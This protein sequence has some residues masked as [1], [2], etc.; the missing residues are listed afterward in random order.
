[1]TNRPLALIYK[2]QEATL[3][4]ANCVGGGR[5]LVGQNLWS[6]LLRWFVWVLLAVLAS[7]SQ[8]HAASYTLPLVIGSAPFDC[9]L[10]SGTTY[11]CPASITLGNDDSVAASSASLT[12]NVAGDVTIPNNV[13]W[14]NSSFDINVVAT[15]TVTLGNSSNTDFFGN[16]TAATVDMGN[17]ASVSGTCTTNGSFSNSGNCAGGAF[18]NGCTSSTSGTVTTV[19]CTSNGSFT[20]PS[21]IT[22][23][24]VEAWGG[25]G[26]G[27]AATGNPDK[28]GGGAGGQYAYK[29][30]SVSSSTTYTVVVGAGGAGGNSSTGGTGGDST[31]NTNTV[32]AK[33]GAGGG[34]AGTNGGDGAAASGSATGGIG[35]FV[36]RGGNSTAGNSTTQCNNGGAGGGGAGIIGNGGNASGNT[37]GTGTAAGG[38]N[39]GAGIN[40]SGDGNAGNTLGGGGGGACAE[41]NANT[42]GG[43]GAAGRV[44]IT[45]S[46]SAPSPIADWRMD[47]TTAYAGVA[48]E[49]KNSVSAGTNATAKRIAKTPPHPFPGNISGKLCG[50][51]EF[52]GFN[53]LEVVGLSSQL[54]GTA[55]L[56]FWVKTT[57][58]GNNTPWAAPG[59][60]GV[61][62]G[63]SNDI[64]WGYINATGKMALH[65]GSTAGAQSTT[66]I[67]D[68]TWR[69]IVLTRNTSSP[70]ESNIYVNGV[71]EATRSMAADLSL[72]TT[73]FS[74]LGR[75]ETPYSSGLSGALD[76]LKIFGPVLSATQVA[77]I[78]ANESAGKN[79]DGSARV[80]P[81]SGPDHYELSLPSISISCLPTTV[82]VT[83]CADN[84]SPCTNPVTTIAGKTAV[85]ATSAGTLAATTVTFNAAG[86]AST[87][88]AYPTATDG[89][90]ATVTLSGEQ[91]AATNPRKSCPDGANCV[92]GNSGSTTFKT[93]GFI[94]T[95]AADAVETTFSRQTSGED[96][97]PYWLRAVKTN[98][99][100]KACEAA[101]TAPHP[102]NFSYQCLDPASCSSGSFLKIGAASLASSGAAINLSFDANGKANLGNF[103][104]TD[105]GQIKIDANAT[106]GGATL[107]GSTKE[108]TG[109]HFVVKPYSLV[110]TDIKQTDSRN[111]DNPAAAS[112]ADRKFIKAGEPFSAKVTSVNALC[113]ANLSSYTSFA[114]IPATCITPNYG[115]EFTPE[116]ATLTSQLVNGLGL[117]NNLDLTNPSAFGTF[118]AGS[119]TG[120]TFSWGEVGIITLTP[121]VGGDGNYLGAGNVTGTSSGNV[122]R[123]YPD[124]FVV[125]PVT[126]LLNRRLA[127]CS[128][129]SNFTYSGEEMELQN[130]KL[131][132]YSGFSS[133]AVT[134]NYSGAFARFDGNV[135]TNFKFGAVDLADATAPLTATSVALGTSAGQLELL[136]SSGSWGTGTDAGIGTFSAKV[137]L[138]RAASL[139]GPY[140]S[141]NLG[142]VPIDLDEVTVLTTA[143]NL[144]TNAP[145]DG[146]KDKVLVGSTKVRFGRL[147]LQNNYG[148]ERLPLSLPIQAQYWNGSS[149]I[150]N[151][152]DNC[153]ALTVPDEKTIA[154]GTSPGDAAGVYFYSGNPKNQLGSGDTAGTWVGSTLAAGRS[155]LNFT[156]PLKPGWLD[157]TLGVDSWLQYNWGNCNGQSGA[158]ST[159]LINNP[160]ARATFGIYKSPLIYRR[161]NY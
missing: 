55:S 40:D 57:Q 85:L 152:D 141:F 44:V 79:W 133:S 149:F 117:S 69:H 138:S 99:T 63:T 11:N 29:L 122:G 49:A 17:N 101:L 90:V 126:S 22:L 112:A 124:H 4:I 153:T 28:G 142:I 128:S 37:G 75:V 95:T 74:S 143:K 80:C 161:E 98:T 132:A 96:F 42:N 45:Y 60:S 13:T 121:S 135:V 77:S 109:S 20:P 26:G 136:S 88:L 70:G 1:M 53:Y 72:V 148:S 64:F 137:R 159:H 56:S 9:T 100:T 21:G 134:K 35:D 31:F 18:V 3:M 105:V 84:S 127:S 54:S 125:T 111:L 34:Y 68:G 10:V 66:S 61:E 58:T 110:V 93:A 146:T 157:L 160:C 43:A 38:G 76:E 106:V 113:S 46:T 83:A 15:G 36:Y 7:A 104:F 33:G 67:N 155:K 81:A 19:T 14:G 2:T 156:T 59:V 97:G 114:S 5:V 71:L 51:V 131:T 65:K 92:V 16:I 147:R 91:A 144:D 82:T 6:P 103:N 94:F 151:A 41:S 108:A 118:S 8:T 24:L 50:G 23:A 86:V 158:D 12:L 115:K 154:T 62:V 130:F 32:V 25:G 102:V 145:A 78:Y 52:N 120:T 129:A 140:E 87:T 27:G 123:F 47:E 73:A 107:T 139:D 30:L 48:G 150:V 119:A 39:G 116:T 89:A